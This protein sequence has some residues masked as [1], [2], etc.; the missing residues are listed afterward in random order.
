MIW[1][2]IKDWP[3]A[4]E[5][6]GTQYP[7]VADAHK[8]LAGVVNFSSIN[9]LTK[10]KQ[11]PESKPECVVSMGATV[12][13]ITVRQYMT[14]PSTPD[15]DFMAKWNN[16]IPMPLRTMVGTVEKETSGMVYMH[17]HGDITDTVTQN[18]MKC[19]KAITNPVSQFFGMG[20][21]CGNHNYVNPFDSDEEL[22]AV[23]E[24]Y[25]RNYLQKITWSGWVIKSAI[26]EREE[27]SNA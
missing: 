7:S 20:P 17:L 9:L 22:K 6:D 2:Q 15:F 18:C 13:K 16:D 5:I 24:N 3:G 23:V 1:E 19:G 27:V 4:V 12:Y 14:K 8:S 10:Q 11:A 25:R 26:L 21:E